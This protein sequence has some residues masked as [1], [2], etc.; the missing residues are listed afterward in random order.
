MLFTKALRE[1]VGAKDELAV[2]EAIERF[3]CIS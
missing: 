2:R 1:A 3:V